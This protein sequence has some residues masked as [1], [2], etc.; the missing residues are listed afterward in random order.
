[1]R[2][3]VTGANGGVGSTIIDLLRETDA[4][5]RATCRRPDR[6]RWPSVDV[7]PGDLDE[8]QTLRPALRSVDAVF[9]V[10]FA[11][12]KVLPDLVEE[13][14]AAGVQKVVVLS[15]ID[16]T[17]TEQFVEYNKQRHL[18]V[19]NAAIDGGFATVCLRPGAF[20]RNAIRFWAHQIRVH[21]S[22]GLPFPESQQAPIADDDIAAVGVTALTT[23]TLD[24]QKIVL[25]GPASLTMREQVGLIGDAI[26]HPIDITALSDTQARALYGQVLPPQ[27]LDLLMAQW[28]FEVTE[29][30]EVTDAVPT[31]TGRP[32]IPFGDWA[33][34]H[35]EAFVG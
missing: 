35:R 20:A 16:T 15:T 6:R 19:E 13:M 2:V 4:E 31:I 9:L 17:R 34:R 23:S 8:P 22:V 21:R 1:M 32:A 30:A 7:V 18:A 27:Y 14:T 10:S 12:P 28:A 3:L 24:G 33:V 5:V 26:S 25:T 29:P 11:P